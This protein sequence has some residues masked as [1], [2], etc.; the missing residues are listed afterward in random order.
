MNNLNDIDDYRYTG[1]WHYCVAVFFLLWLIFLPSGCN[2]KQFK[3][4]ARVK[5]I[6]RV[7]AGLEKIFGGLV[8]TFILS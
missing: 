6:I 3:D 4:P 7:D 5:K 8:K 1:L 2:E